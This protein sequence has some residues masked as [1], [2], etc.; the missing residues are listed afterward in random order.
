MNLEGPDGKKIIFKTI[1]T[2]C[3]LD[4]KPSNPDADQFLV[5]IK[6]LKYD[7]KENNL[8]ETEI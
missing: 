3:D 5:V 1:L 8:S 6:E 4:I 2:Y 7:W